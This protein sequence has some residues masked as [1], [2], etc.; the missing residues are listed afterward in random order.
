MRDRGAT[1]EQ[2]GGD[3]ADVRVWFQD[4]SW[5]DVFVVASMNQW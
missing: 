5:A 3:I 4:D 1:K 2:N